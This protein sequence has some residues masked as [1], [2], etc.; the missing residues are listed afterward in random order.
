MVAAVTRVLTGRF[1]V[2]QFDPKKRTVP[3]DELT[4]GIIFSAE[5]QRL[6][7]EAT[8]QS[9]VLLRN[10]GLLP[11]SKPT[12][13][14]VFGPNGNVSGVFQGQYVGPSCP[15]NNTGN[16]CH[17]T[18]LSAI[19]KANEGGKTTFECGCSGN[20]TIAQECTSLVNLDR[21]KALGTEADIIFLFLGLQIGVTNEESRDRPHNVSGY[22]LPG[23]QEQ[24][25]L[26]I[27]ALKKPTVL[28]L[29][30]GMAI[31]FTQ[32]LPEWAVVVTGYGGPFA[33]RNCNRSKRRT[34]CPRA[35]RCA[36][37]PA[38]VRCTS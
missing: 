13:I 36:R 14:A 9:I 18:A 19:V 27:A 28:F 30:S 24:L 2:G 17:D 11:L 3:Y 33:A 16:S 38:P 31:D 1:Q 20:A 7:L 35:M 29:V 22:K 34:P 37:P 5:H 8:Q 12:N 6:S 23:K 25:A 15:G 4:T 26:A 10:P 32:S 21:V